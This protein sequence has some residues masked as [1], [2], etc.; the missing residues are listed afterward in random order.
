MLYH[1]TKNPFLVQRRLGHKNIRNTQIYVQIDETIFQSQ[2]DEFHSAAASNVQE[3]RQLVEAGFDY[4]C[5]FEGVK[6]FKK[7]K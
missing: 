3:A 5:E 7:R 1:K 2:S 6:I 4:V